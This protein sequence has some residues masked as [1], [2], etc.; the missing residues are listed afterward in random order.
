MRERE[1]GRLTDM[2]VDSG[3]ADARVEQR[4]RNDPHARRGDTVR[5][6]GCLPSTSKSKLT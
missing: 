4:D 5:S 6:S 1:R 3:S 2:I